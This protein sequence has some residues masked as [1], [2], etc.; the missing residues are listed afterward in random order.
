MLTD[1][2]RPRALKTPEDI[3]AGLEALLLIVEEPVTETELAAA[4]GAPTSVVVDALAELVAFYAETGR[5]FEL[6]QVGG[7]WRYYTR[8]EHADLISGYLLDGQQSKLSQAALETLAVVAYQQPI[9]RARV[10]AVRGVS[11]DGVM[12]TL[13]NRGLVVEA[14][15]DHETGAALFR[16]TGYFLERMGLRGLDELP[17]LAPHLPEVTE[18]E[19]ELSQLARPEPVPDSLADVADR[20]PSHA[21]HSPD[22]ESQ[23][24]P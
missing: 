12:R 11:V 10:S 20:D 8:D 1:A 14:G 23:D 13:L 4:L 24:S 22:P 17:A 18:L 15:H 9:S 21:A 19:A 16:T 6:R 7:G 5:G 3:S 2:D